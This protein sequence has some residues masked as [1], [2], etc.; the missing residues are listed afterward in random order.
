MGDLTVTAAN[1]AV[2]RPLDAVIRSYIA[3][4]AITAGQAVYFT[5]AGKAGVADANDSGK[6]QFRG[7]ALKT[8][9]AGQAV[10]VLH[11]GEI[12]GFESLGNADTILYLSNTAGK[13]ATSSGSTAVA[14][15]RVVCL[16]DSPT[17]TK[18]VRVF[19]RWSAD[20]A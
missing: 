9:G 7:I 20:W 17:L 16:S 1:V 14:A 3:V 13:L 5:T 15:G 2:V 8:V 19:T 10:D 12:Y 4:A 18:V 11:E 6:I